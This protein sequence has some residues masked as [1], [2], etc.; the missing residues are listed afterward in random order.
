MKKLIPPLLAVTLLIT[1]AV[2]RL[3]PAAADKLPYTDISA[4]YAKDAIIRLHDD[5]VMK[6]TSAS[7]FSPTRSITRAEFMTTL[8]RIFQVNPAE[9]AIPAYRDVPKSAWYYGT[10]Q[11]ATELGL[12]EGL[13]NGIFQ[14]D[15]PL[16]RQEAA[17]WLVRALKQTASSTNV[18]AGYKDEAAIA[19]WAK[20]YIGSISQ[21][22]LMQGN[23]G[24]FFPAQAIT[25]Q[26]T[27]VLLDRLLQD[28]RW[29]NAITASGHSEVR[30]G[31]QYGQSTEAYKKSVLQSNVNV[32]A[33]RWYF[34]ESTGKISDSS[35]P[36]LV[37]WAKNNGKQVWAMVG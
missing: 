6:G 25:R 37:T 22:G 16:T 33:P 2:F 18:Q 28:K 31:W 15:Q 9:S 26:E 30:I 29:T 24:M 13:G 35:V 1:A 32:L 36:T 4:S 14:P 5:N 17:A 10:I 20:P 34:L 19:V 3:E 7:M 8:T 23:G 12:T 27:A 21:L 11:A